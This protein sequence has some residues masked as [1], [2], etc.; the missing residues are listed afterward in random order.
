MEN[1]CWNRFDGLQPM[2]RTNHGAG[3]NSEGEGVAEWSC[4]ELTTS[5]PSPS[6]CATQGVRR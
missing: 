1:L 3:E 4:Y 6:L 2:G 5:P